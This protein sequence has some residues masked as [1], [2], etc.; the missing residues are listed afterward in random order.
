MAQTFN[1]KAKHV[2]SIYKDLLKIKVTD[3][4][5]QKDIE[6]NP[7]YPSLLSISDTF[8]RYRIPNSAYQVPAEN[9]GELFTPRI[10]KMGSR[11]PSVHSVLLVSVEP[12]R[13]FVRNS[14]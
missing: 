10:V 8:D 3:S 11:R 12:R 2:A 7:F 5:L 14:R 9:F 1:S 6:E 4:T 13:S